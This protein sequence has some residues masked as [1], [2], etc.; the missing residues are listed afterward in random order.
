MGTG[1]FTGTP[2]SPPRD[3]RVR[4]AVSG[5][6][7]IPPPTAVGSLARFLPKGWRGMETRV[8]ADRDGYAEA[9]LR[10]G[11][12]EAKITILDGPRPFAKGRYEYA[13]DA[14]DGGDPLVRLH[15]NET[16][17]L[18]GGRFEVKI[19]SDELDAVARS[20]LLETLDLKALRT[21]AR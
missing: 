15:D 3:L 7:P 2:P 5:I 17:A 4:P 21:A 20:E 9:V 13:R 19:L 1:T 6:A 11:K 10:Q 14:T 18:V 12:V 8:T 16:S